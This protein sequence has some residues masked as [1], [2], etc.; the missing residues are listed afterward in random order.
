MS[1]GGGPNWPFH[2]L[3]ARD[4]LL[5]TGFAFLIFLFLGGGLMGSVREAGVSAGVIQI[6]GAGLVTLSL[7]IPVYFILLRPGRCQPADLGLIRPDPFWIR[8]GIV[9]GL[10][11]G[12]L[13]W[14]IGGFVDPSEPPGSKTRPEDTPVWLVGLTL[15]VYYGFLAPIA[16]EVFFRGLLFNWVRS[17]I[18]FLPAAGASSLAFGIL[19]MVHPVITLLYLVVGMIM[20][21]LF[22]QSRSLVPSILAHQTFAIVWTGLILLGAG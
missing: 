1:P 5:V 16:Q 22:E 21:W 8:A 6:V 7:L 3:S 10:V 15:F 20:A 14:L 18:S 9:T 17:R 19:Y 11:L 4:V 2:A 13:A 12:P